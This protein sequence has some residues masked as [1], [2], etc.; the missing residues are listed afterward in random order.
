MKKIIFAFAALISSPSIAQSACSAAPVQQTACELLTPP[1]IPGATV[2][3]STAEERHNLTGFTWQGPIS[4]CSLKT[5][6][7]HGDS[8]DQVRIEV[9][10]PLEPE[11]PWNGYFKGNGGAGFVA[12]FFD[13]SL[14]AAVSRGYATAST[15]AGVTTDIT[16]FPALWAGDPQL[17]LNYAHLSIHEMTAFGKAVTADFYGQPASHSFF[18]GCSRGGQQGFEEAMRYPDDY[19]G[20]LARDPAVGFDR[21]GVSVIWGFMLQSMGGSFV[22]SCKQDAFLA[23]TISHCDHLDGAED[24]LIS[25]PPDCDFDPQSIVGQA[26]SCADGT[27]EVI[28]EYDASIWQSVHEGPRRP[29]GSLAYFG[30]PHGA[31]FSVYLDDDSNSPITSFVRDFV[32][33]DPN[34]N[35]STIDVD[36]FWEIWARSIELYHDLWGTDNDD[37]SPFKNSGGKLLTWQGWSD[38]NA[39]PG[40]NTAFW[41]RVRDVFE[42]DESA[43][44]DFYR[45]FLVPGIAHCDDPW[46]AD[47]RELDVLV[48]W[49]VNDNAPETLAKEI[50]EARRNACKHPKKLSYRG[51]GDV[52]DA[53][54]WE[55]IE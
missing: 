40:A 33:N 3:N 2:I 48:D 9:W 4:V 50:G 24:G 30:L 22:S 44:D 15:D 49:V 17:E 54:S 42:G 12:G 20:I 45:L 27:Q 43:V 37:L 47:S 38:G 46:F 52:N 32:L 31:S 16:A 53:D 18:T 39:P 14:G 51:S 23:A 55:C 13:E 7:T 34:Y 5:Y 19:D 35:M 1:T 25:H 11:T 29:D 36:Q 10:L 26:A 8:G 21:G 6:I 41:A 28:T